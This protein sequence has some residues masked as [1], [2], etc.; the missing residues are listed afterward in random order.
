VGSSELSEAPTLGDGRLMGGLTY[1]F[2]KS[3][4]L[5]NGMASSRP[6]VGLV[7]LEISPCRSFMATDASSSLFPP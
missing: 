1:L 2:A 4:V 7:D 6:A 5:N 3:S